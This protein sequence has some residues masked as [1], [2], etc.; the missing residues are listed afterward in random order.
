MTA[1]ITTE[2]AAILFTVISLQGH[3]SLREEE[4]SVTIL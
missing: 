2:R 1:L 3:A 4:G